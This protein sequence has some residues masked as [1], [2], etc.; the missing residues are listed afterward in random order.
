[1]YSTSICE[2][3]FEYNLRLLFS[4]CFVQFSFEVKAYIRV[5]GNGRQYGKEGDYDDKS[6]IVHK[7]IEIAFVVRKGRDIS[8]AIQIDFILFCLR[9]NIVFP[10]QNFS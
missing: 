10:L 4:S 7:F 8:S 5:K 3:Y 2:K 1:M 9:I 6:C